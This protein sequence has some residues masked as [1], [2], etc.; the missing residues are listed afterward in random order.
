MGFFFI[1]DCNAWSCSSHLA[2]M[3]GSKAEIDQGKVSE[4]LTMG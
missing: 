2:A 3:W 4:K 1:F